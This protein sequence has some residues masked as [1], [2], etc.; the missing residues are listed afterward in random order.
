MIGLCLCYATSCMPPNQVDP[1]FSQA[2]KREWTRPPTKDAGPVEWKGSK[3]VSRVLPYPDFVSLFIRLPIAHAAVTGKGVKVAVVQGGSDKTTAVLVENIAPGAEVVVVPCGAK[4]A[5]DARLGERLADSGCRVAIV[6]DLAVLSEPALLELARD[7]TARRVLVVVPSDLS[8]ERAAI[9]R[10]N[11]LHALGALTVGR[12]NRQSMVM[13][14]SSERD[15]AVKP[16]NRQIRTFPTDVFSAVDPMRGLAIGPAATAAGVATLVIEKW[17]ALAPAEISQ[18]IIAGA[19]AVWQGTAIESGRWTDVSVDPVTTRYQPRNEQSVFRFRALDAAGAVGVDTEVPWFLNMLNCPKAW[20][21]T[22]GAGTLVVV[23]DQGFHLKHPELAPH[24]QATNHF[25]PMNFNEPKQNF[26]G[27]DMSRILLAVAPAARIV[28]V[29]CSGKS[30]GAGGDL[31]GNM[32][33]SF[34]YAVQLKADAVSS[35]WA[36]WFNKDE[37]LLGAVRDAV[38]HGV[39][40]SWFHY[41]RPY[42]GLLRSSFTYAAGWDSGQELGFADRFLTDPPGFHPVEIE[43]GLSGTAPQ[44]AGIAALVKSANPKLAPKEIEALIYEQATP[45]GGGVLVP[46]AHKAVLAAKQKAG[47]KT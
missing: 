43:A 14:E 12:V 3:V 2:V 19:R 4:E 34:Q 16:L 47:G 17:P 6:P 24:I 45:I 37:K 1:N 39:V 8:E 46:D 35:S 42:P 21:I 33:R 36:G 40:V 32:A 10:V 7:L 38:D 22:R 25:G 13:V 27:T 29:L 28:P 30:H 20:E 5:G 11:K 44:A 9:E 41:P 18:K 15:E 31:A 23:T 26:H